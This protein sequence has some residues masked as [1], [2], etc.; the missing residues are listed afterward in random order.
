MRLSNL[1][2]AE[3]ARSEST[4][5]TIEQIQMAV[6]RNPDVLR[7]LAALRERYSGAVTPY[8]TSDESD[9]EEAGTGF[10]I[11]GIAA[12]FSAICPPS[13]SAGNYDIQI[14]S[15][16]PGDYLYQG[17]VSLEDFL[18]LIEEY[19]QPMTV[20]RPERWRDE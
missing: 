3:S 1:S 13:P 7:L 18:R 16:P 9:D 11:D 4:R 14:E 15:Y 6:M 2:V 17:N 5:C 8:G 12:T 19:R 10:R 20:W